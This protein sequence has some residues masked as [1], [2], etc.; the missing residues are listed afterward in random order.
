M[1]LPPTLVLALLLSFACAPRLSSASTAWPAAAYPSNRFGFNL[2]AMQTAMDA[3]S[4]GAGG[5]FVAWDDGFHGHVQH[6]LAD[7]RF[8]WPFYVY[9]LTSSSAGYLN[10]ALALDGAGGVFV[11]FE[12]HGGG[13]DLKLQHVL[14]NGSVP[15]G[16]PAGGVSVSSTSDYDYFGDVVPDGLGGAF[17]SFVRTAT[18]RVHVQHVTAQGV[19][20]P[21]WPASG[22]PVMTTATTTV[23]P[24][25]FEDGEGGVL[26]LHADGAYGS[27][28]LRVSRVSGFGLLRTDLFPG[29]GLTLA[30][31]VSA[32][33]SAVRTGD[34]VVGV[35]WTDAR[36]GSREVY[37]DVLDQNGRTGAAPAGGLALTATPGVN[38]DYVTLT[39]NLYRDFLVTWVAGTQIVAARRQQDL[40]LHPSFPTGLATVCPSTSGALLHLSIDA[41]ESGGLIVGWHDI[42][43]L[44][45][46]VQHLG[47]TGAPVSGWPAGGVVLATHPNGVGYYP[48]VFSDFDGGVIGVFRDYDML[49]ANRVRR[50][51]A[52]GAYVPPVLLMLTDVPNDQGGRLALYWRASERDTLPANPV[53]S[54]A[55]WRRMPS[56][57]SPARALPGTRLLAAG[58]APLAGEVG[59]LRA[60]AHGTATVYWEYLGSTPSRGWAGYGATVSTNSDMIFAVDPP[61]EMFMVETLSPTGAVL[62]TSVPDSGFSMDN[63]APLAPAGPAAVRVANATHLHWLPNGESDF[64][65][66]RIHR[67]PTAGFAPDDANRIGATR[68]TGWA[69]S[70]PAGAY[71]KLVAVDVHGNRS[72]PTLVTPAQTLD[73]PAIAASLEFAPVAPNPARG[74]ATLAFTTPAA[75]Q[76]RLT[77]YDAQGRLARALVDAS[78]PAGSH[79][80][81][82]DL[83][84]ADGRALAPGLY[85]ARL[86]TPAGERTR[87][88]VIVP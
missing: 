64:G 63:L 7:G 48:R 82:W 55:V 36:T 13:D 6:V 40:S 10:P 12:T 74:R 28:T 15:P 88:F 11:A 72:A 19:P 47:F 53:G 75:G 68:D 52:Q 39:S 79:A 9:D 60:E 70:G 67:G 46:R 22:V 80:Q 83:S 59:A 37:I 66:Y 85:L 29:D 18:S 31:G 65:E 3:A 4:D 69:D 21:A 45:V 2:T 5:L 17:V 32:N 54:Y 57:F 84:G 27:G 86:A 30:T 78:L 25:L 38:E 81:A 61:W 51:G 20:D 87:R 1:R 24:Q 49:G 14:A 23:R 34:G 43:E 58:E 42:A 56:I 62:G 50:D 71:Y 26:V 8:A 76:V 16:W 41:D 33:F 35:A 73:A 44:H 77:V